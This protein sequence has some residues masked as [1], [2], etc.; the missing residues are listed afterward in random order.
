M[1]TA[2]EGALWVKNIFCDITRSHQQETL[3]GQ[4]ETGQQFSLIP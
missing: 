1:S 4:K 3:T 2:E